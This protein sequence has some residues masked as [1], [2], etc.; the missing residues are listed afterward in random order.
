MAV[1]LQRSMGMQNDKAR[2]RI[3]LGVIR[4][5]NTDVTSVWA[6]TH[7][8]Y[9]HIK[10]DFA[11]LASLCAA[12]FCPPSSRYHII[13]SYTVK[14]TSAGATH[15]WRFQCGFT[16]RQIQNYSIRIYSRILIQHAVI[17]K[18]THPESNFFNWTGNIPCW[19]QY[20]LNLHVL[21]L[22]FSRASTTDIVDIELVKRNSILIRYHLKSFKF[23]GYYRY[24]PI[25]I[26]GAFRTP[27][28][29]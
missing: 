9:S 11:F 24:F 21:R 14:W 3:V 23:P 20:T 28:A 15:A 27:R 12:A 29:W 13:F 7:V 10:R 4:Y 19:S 26:E 25:C 1:Y 5:D 6:R 2:G 16:Y 22:Q 17:P 18:L 8:P